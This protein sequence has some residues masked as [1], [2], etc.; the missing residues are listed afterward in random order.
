MLKTRVFIC[1]SI[2][3]SQRYVKRTSNMDVQ[4]GGKLLSI[5]QKMWILRTFAIWRC[6]RPDFNS[7]FAEIHICIFVQAT[8]FTGV[9]LNFK[10]E[11]QRHFLEAKMLIEGTHKIWTSIFCVFASIS[12]IFPTSSGTRLRKATNGA[13]AL[14]R[15][16]QTTHFLQ[17]CKFKK[18]R[19]VGASGWKV[20]RTHPYLQSCKYGCVEVLIFV[21]FRL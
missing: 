9:V 12:S 18:R 11:R 7:A 14:R 13:K 3:L 4:I 2:P 19:L 10:V 5:G 16:K 21:K 20:L 8:G 1:E 17:S 6:G 15:Q